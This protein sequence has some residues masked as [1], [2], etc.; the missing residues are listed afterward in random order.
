[1]VTLDSTF[2]SNGKVVANTAPYDQGFSL[3][4]QPDSKV[5]V[6]GFSYNGV[7]SDFSVFRFNSNGPL[8]TGFGVNGEVTTD[9]LGFDI[10]QSVALQSDGKILVGGR[11]FFAGNDFAIARYNSNGS[12]DTSFNGNGLRLQ[13][14]DGG[15]DEITALRLQSD[16]KILATG[17]ADINGDDDFAIARFNSDGSLDTSFGINGKAT[18]DF[19]GAEDD[20]SDS[21]IQSDGKSLLIGD[22]KVDGDR[23]FALARFN[24]N[25]TLDTSFGNGRKVTT[26][27][28][29]LDDEALSAVI[30]ADGKILVAG[31]STTTSG[32]DFALVRYNANGTLDTSFGNGGKV[33]TDFAG[34]DDGAVSVHLQPNGK[35]ILTGTAQNSSDSDFA[36]ARYN[37]DGTLDTSFGTNGKITTNFGKGELVS[38]SVLHDGVLTLVGS[39]YDN[40]DSNIALARYVLDQKPSDLSLSSLTIQENQPVGATVGTFTTTDSD[41]GDTFTYTLVTGT[42]STDNA[43]FTIEGNTLKTKQAFDFETKNAYSIRVRSTDA[44]GLSTEK[45]LK[46]TVGDVREIVTPNPKGKIIGTRENDRLAGT[47]KDDLIRGLKGNDTL[48][49]RGGNDIL[50]GGLGNDTLKGGVGDDVLRGGAG[51][52]TFFLQNNGIDTIQSFSDGQDKLKLTG[53]LTFGSLTITQQGGDTLISAGSSQ[54]AI[55]VGVNTSQITAADFV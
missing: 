5:V 49:G 36:V 26:D 32:R 40:T 14:F 23:D 7:D 19:D 21:L 50:V 43:G 53:G 3:V 44:Y 16:G 28:A 29:G 17:S 15:D 37:S 54:F 42:G 41:A 31:D 25:G 2:G 4:L 52:D 33:T 24:S 35:I 46:I 45:E 13:D 55:L 48:N 34:F 12:L 9:I 47:A 8:D 11:A 51:K 6:G 10:G 22:A 27:F 20:A 18:V 30:Q 1:M 38:E 39:S